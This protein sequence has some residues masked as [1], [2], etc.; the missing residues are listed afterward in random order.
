MTERFSAVAV[1]IPA[2]N[3]EA[4]LPSVLRD[5]PRVGRVVVADNGSSDGTARV[6]REGGAEVVL[7]LR[8]GYGSAVLAAIE[9]LRPTPPKVLVVLDADGSDDTARLADLVGPILDDAADLVLSDRSRTA[10]PGSLTL[11]QRFGNQL[12]TR[13]MYLASGYQYQDLGPFRAVRWESLMDLGMRDPT[14]GWNVEMQLKAVRRG[15]RI[16]EVP[17]PYEGRK[18]GVS[19]ISGELRGAARAGSRI[20]WAVKEYRRDRPADLKARARF[21]R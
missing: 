16:L 4:S 7:A 19:K 1:A 3:E 15:L 18:A 12:A 17:L 20:L 10:S 14:W 5:L 9:H 13:L 6:A 21:A 11:P 8:R 2:L